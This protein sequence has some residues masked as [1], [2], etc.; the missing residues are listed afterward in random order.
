MPPQPSSPDTLITTLAN[1][2]RLVAI[3][4]PHLSTA[5]VAVYVRSGSAHE[6]RAQNGISHVVEH[7]VFKGTRERDARRI[8]LDAERLGAEVNAHTDKDHTAY[9]MRG[10]PQHAG[11]FVAM[12]SDLVQH[13]TFPADELER[14]RQVLL[15]ECTE[16]EDD[17]VDT[18]Y[19]LFDAA[20]F[21]DHAAARPVIGTRRG[22]ERLT[23]DEL[24]Q[25]VQRQYSGANLVLAAAGAIDVD[26]LTRQ[27]E[28]AFGALAPGQPNLV[29]PPVYGGGIRTR[30]LAGSSQT[31]AVLGFPIASLRDGGDDA[32]ATL[33][34]A[35]FGEGMSSPLLHEL[36][37]KRALV[38]HAMCSADVLDMCGQFV[39]E[40]ST[41]PAQFDE[42]LGAVLGLLV[43]HAEH[44][45]AQDF[46]R[47]RNQIAVRRLRAHDKPS[48]RLEAAALDL[49]VHGRVRTQAERLAAIESVSAEAV[50][51]AFEQMLAAGLSLAITG[52]VKR[53]AGHRAQEIV[54][55]H[56]G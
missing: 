49:F 38:Y 20:C 12:L 39:L 34:A 29:A 55:R 45:D 36:R 7:M 24:A 25:Y 23:R 53:A 3:P 44:V 50:R 51:A 11:E 31:H 15:H 2:V 5:S 33:A 43:K 35:V 46:E 32:A 9:Y 52:Q 40:A 28:A 47:A 42:F 37:E 6:T 27:A 30:S 48:R 16:V 10:L 22:I 21:G 18:A 17:P 13:A 54:A 56:L 4:S 41:A 19:H 8:N 1:G 26:A 14:E